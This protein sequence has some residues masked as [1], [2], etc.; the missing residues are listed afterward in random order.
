MNAVSSKALKVET[1][2]ALSRFT[3]TLTFGSSVEIQLPEFESC[4]YQTFY[5]VSGPAD[6]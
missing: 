6:K 2:L 5:S 4:Y 1:T 3:I